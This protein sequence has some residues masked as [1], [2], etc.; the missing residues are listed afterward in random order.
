MKKA[1]HSGKFA[2]EPPQVQAVGSVLYEEHLKLTD[3]S[4]ITAFSGY[5]MPLWYSSISAEHA[6]VRQT[7]GVFDCT[8][9]GVWE[10]SGEK[11]AE[12]L[13]LVATND[14]TGL[15]AS[16][17]QYSY[18]LDAAGNIL[19]DIIIYK[20]DENKFM[21][22]VNA[23]NNLK[24][25]AYLENLENNRVVIDTDNPDRK[26][27]YKPVIR[28]M[29]DVNTGADCKVDIALQGPATKDV[30]F[31]IIADKK[32]RESIENL[33]PFHLIEVV[34]EGFG[35]IIS[36]TGY[37]GAKTGFEL[38][39][40]PEK[41]PQIWNMLMQGGAVPCGLGARDSLRIEAGLPLYG[42]ELA[43]PFN[44]S[45]FEAGYGWAVKLEKEFFIGKS[46]M[47]QNAKTY[48]MKVARIKLPS[49]KGIR[50]VRQN[51]AVLDKTEMCIG[52]VLSCAK[53]GERQIALA[54][55]N[56]DVQENDRVGI[57]YAAR[58]QNQVQQGRKQNIQKGQDLEADITGTLVSRFAKF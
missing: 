37:T 58:N 53:V 39:V 45:P 57:Y 2:F 14:I 30:L 19:D 48:N 28:D 56:K 41:A 36:R 17:A 6:A 21:M 31:A 26:L 4:H 7:A 12:F 8:H 5:L 10:I 55:I 20:R 54:H 32:I 27:K 35:F 38:F 33:K 15:L 25:K 18:I 51:D 1:D 43:G 16:G 46:A 9:M 44:I 49:M 23:A 11:A 34:L 47:Q 3:K 50:P 24:I 52:F 13:N 29:K 40:H 22:V 42:H